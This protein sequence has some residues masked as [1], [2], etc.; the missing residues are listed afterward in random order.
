M[1]KVPA[2][3]YGRQTPAADISRWRSTSGAVMLDELHVTDLKLAPEVRLHLARD[4][5]I[6][7]ARLEAEAK[8]AVPAPF[9]ASAWAGGQALAR[10]L[11]DHPEVVRGKRVL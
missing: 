8:S 2:G 4:A 9:W 10:Y 5:I 11:L 3:T 6:L 7:W 1:T